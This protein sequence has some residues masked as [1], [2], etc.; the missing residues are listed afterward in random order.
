M[1]RIITFVEKI[2]RSLFQTEAFE[3]RFMDSDSWIERVESSSAH[4]TFVCSILL[5]HTTVARR[6]L[7]FFHPPFCV[8]QRYDIVGRSTAGKIRKGQLIVY[9]T[10]YVL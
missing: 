5:Q 8:F 7:F 2:S 1:N 10:V 9:M 4:K 3:I 6:P